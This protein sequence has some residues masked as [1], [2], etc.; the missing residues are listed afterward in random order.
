MGLGERCDEIVR[1]IDETLAAIGT[2]PADDT[3]GAS[4]PGASTPGP[5]RQVARPV[6]MV[7]A[8]QPRQPRQPRSPVTPVPPSALPPDRAASG[9]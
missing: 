6:P 3:S 8:R 9:F 7:V 1:L 5:S 2:A 4:T